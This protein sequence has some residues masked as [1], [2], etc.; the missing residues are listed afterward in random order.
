V[1][2]SYYGTLPAGSTGPNN[3]KQN[4]PGNTTVYQSEVTPLSILN[5]QN[6]ITISMGE[7]SDFIFFNLSN[8]SLNNISAKLFDNRGALVQTK[9]DMHPSLAYFMPIHELASG[10]YTLIMQSGASTWTKQLQKK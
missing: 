8:Q 2:P 9:L 3:T 7:N 5:P 10:S 4:I 6:E 1:G